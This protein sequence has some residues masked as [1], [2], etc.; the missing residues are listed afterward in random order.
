MGWS[1]TAATRDMDTIFSD[2]EKRRILAALADRGVAD[3]CPR[4]G[5]NDLAVIDG[6]LVLRP[7][8]Q[9]DTSILGG[10][11]VATAMLVC[12]H[13]GHIGLHAL[14]RLDGPPAG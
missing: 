3:C 11:S 10:P 7:Q 2:Q 9:M 6:Y 1:R 5:R 14:D 4:C 12:T 13:C 8:L